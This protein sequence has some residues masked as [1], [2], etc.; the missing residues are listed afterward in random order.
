MASGLCRHNTETRVD[1]DAC[2]VYMITGH[3]FFSKHKGA[4]STIDALSMKGVGS[5]RTRPFHAA[6]PHGRKV[7][8]VGLKVDICWTQRPSR[9]QRWLSGR[10]IMP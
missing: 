1:N 6:F 4:N 3:G 9:A 8:G 10:L 5:S 2:H 7:P